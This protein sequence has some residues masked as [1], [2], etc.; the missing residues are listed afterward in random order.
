M[1]VVS[2]DST[3][4][5][6]TPQAFLAKILQGTFES[7]PG[8]K[9]NGTRLLTPKVEQQMLARIKKELVKP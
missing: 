8:H 3:A 6:N 9:K 2:R 1:A 7:G 4:K 5:A